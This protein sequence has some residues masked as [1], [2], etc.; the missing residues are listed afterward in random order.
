MDSQVTVTCVLLGTEGCS[1]LYAHVLGGVV[2]PTVETASCLPYPVLIPSFLTNRT[3][4][5]GS[6]QKIT[7]PRL[8]CRLECPEIYLEVAESA[9]SP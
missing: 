5:N 4:G 2:N 7:F 1:H 9:F 3:L 8:I 6:V